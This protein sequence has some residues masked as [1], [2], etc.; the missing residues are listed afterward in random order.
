MEVS[1]VQSLTI[2]G[3]PAG[4]PCRRLHIT[5]D[6]ECFWELWHLHAALR[7]Q[8]LIRERK[9]RW[10][11]DCLVALGTVS[12]LAAAPTPWSYMGSQ[13]PG[14]LRATVVN[15]VALLALLWRLVDVGRH[16]GLVERARRYLADVG[17]RAAEASLSLP[18][19]QFGGHG[20]TLSMHHGRVYGLADAVAR[21]QQQVRTTFEDC[22]RRLHEAQLVA[23]CLGSPNHT[24]QD[25]LT[26]GSMFLR[27]RRQCSKNVPGATTMR[28]LAAL[29]DTLLAWTAGAL[30]H[31]LVAFY[32]PNHPCRAPPSSVNLGRRHG[33][34]YMYLDPDKVWSLLERAR[35]AGCSVRQ[36]IAA[37]DDDDPQAFVCSP[38]QADRWANKMQQMHFAAQ[39]REFHGVRHICIVADPAT[40]SN[41]EVMAS[42]AY[43]W[44]RDCGTFPFLQFVTPGKHLTNADHALTDEVLDL[45]VRRKL[46]R[47]SAF[48]QL[49]ALSHVALQLTG[50][51]IWQFKVPNLELRPVA[52]GEVRILQPR[53]QTVRALLVNVNT[54]AAT[55]V[56]PDD[57]Q[58]APLL[59]ACLDQGSIGAAG[60]WFAAFAMQSLVFPAFDKF[61]RVVRDIK[62]ALKHAA[63]GVFLK[64]QLFTSVIFG[65]NY[66]PYSTGQFHDQKRRLLEV[67]LSSEDRLYQACSCFSA[68][69]CHMIVEL[70]GFNGSML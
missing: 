46:E 15:T 32:I 28:I 59:V 21:T 64:C 33:R 40:H 37:G 6:G 25:V 13:E 9:C 41:R 49:Q 48:R 22:W 70:P 62:L 38:G 18:D 2:D 58:D 54:R 53:G 8:D 55:Q 43:S 44:E 4:F 52:A 31:Y 34:P 27:V 39:A 16:S 67:F 24:L 57:L 30:K 36:V 42:V 17:Q 60:M 65:L 26:F 45:A 11:R 14:L 3:D 47:V 29:H 68:W 66:K 63:G 56:V 51:G 50:R 19:H 35:R 1:Q 12:L 10:V 20:F 23:S 5:A 61:H 69:R 7:Q